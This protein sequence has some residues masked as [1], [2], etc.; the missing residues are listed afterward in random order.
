MR[1]DITISWKQLRSSPTNQWSV[2]AGLGQVFVTQ[3]DVEQAL[4]LGENPDVILLDKTAASS[5]VRQYVIQ[6]F[7]PDKETTHIEP[8]KHHLMEPAYLESEQKDLL[9]ALAEAHQAVP[10]NQRQDFIFHLAMIHNGA[11][12]REKLHEFIDQG[13]S[14]LIGGTAVMCKEDI[15]KELDQD[16]VTHPGFPQG[17]LDTHRNDVDALKLQSLIYFRDDTKFFIS[18]QGLAYVQRLSMV[19]PQQIQEKT[20]TI[21]NL[22]PEVL[23]QAK[24]PTA[25]ISYSW[26]D[27]DHKEWVRALAARLREGGV[28]VTLDRWDLVPGDQLTAFM[29]KAVRENDFVLIVC[30]PAY[31]IKSD[32]R[33]GGV[34]YEGDVMTA[35]VSISAN[36]RKF[37]PIHRSG[38]WAKAAPSWLKGSLYINLKGD[39]YSEGQYKDL[40]ET[41]HGQREEAPPVG[42]PPK[43]ASKSDLTSVSLPEI[44]TAE[45]TN[46]DAPIRILRVVIDEIGKPR[47]DGTRG[48]GL[49]AVPFQLSRRPSPQWKSILVETWN[50]PPQFTTMHRPGIARVEGDRLIL[51]GTTIDEVERYHRDTLKLVVERTNQLTAQQERAEAQK[52]EQERLRRQQQEEQIREAAK[53]LNWE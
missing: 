40:R 29:E 24:V 12:P 41:L 35:E 3:E 19:Q 17:S 36:R 21:E 8:D 48:S 18:P 14:V 51:D 1:P 49:Y 5:R 31:K 39:P 47:D 27:D 16:F 7:I 22:T 46:L 37:I 6:H 52:Q 45:T 44:A 30:T 9:V 26:D 28:N 34:G 15:P 11:H 2:V 4:L 20:M 38:E 32:E 25:F 50:F 10:R 53:R 33:K 23:T 43:Q 13:Q 42:S